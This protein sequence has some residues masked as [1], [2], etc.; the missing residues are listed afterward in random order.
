[1]AN[2]KSAKKRIGVNE[3]NRLRNRLYK[4]SVRTLIKRFMKDLEIYNIPAFC[5]L[6]NSSLVWLFMKEDFIKNYLNLIIPVII[7]PTRLK[8][9]LV[10]CHLDSQMMIQL[11]EF[12]KCHQGFLSLKNSIPCRKINHI[13]SSSTIHLPLIKIP[14]GVTVFIKKLSLC[15]NKKSKD[16]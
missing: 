7:H 11:K 15:I 12:S 3:R 16:I 8:S 9:H 6:L 13:F 4:S 2:N 10:L 14:K 5:V 1:M